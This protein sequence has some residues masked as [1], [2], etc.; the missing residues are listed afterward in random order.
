MLWGENSDG[1]GKLKEMMMIY[2]EKRDAD[3][4]WGG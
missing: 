3:G 4:G 2:K 1:E